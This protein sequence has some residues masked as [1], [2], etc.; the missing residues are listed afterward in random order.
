[1]KNSNFVIKNVNLV[2]VENE[3]VIKNIDLLI[4]DGKISEIS[5]N[6]KQ[7][8]YREFDYKDKYLCPGLINLHAHLF[9]SGKPSKTLTGGKKQ[10]FILKIVKTKLGDVIL[11]K[12]AKKS[13]LSELYS[14][15]TTVRSVGDF[16]YAD[17]KQR[18]LINSGK[19]LGPTLYC[20]GFAI[21]AP[22]GHGDK[23]FA[24]SGVTNEDYK[25][26]ID[27]NI[28]EGVDWIK[29]CTTGGVMDA[30]KVGDCGS[31]KMSYEAAKFC[32]EY[33]HEKGYRVA[34]HTEGSEGM[35]EG[36]ALGL[37]TIEHGAPIKD[38][39]FTRK[40]LKD[41]DGNWGHTVLITTISPAIPFAKLDPKI[42]LCDDV[43]KA[44][45]DIVANG[46]IEESKYALAHNITVG[47]GTDASCPYAFQYGMWR[48]L[49]YFK[50]Y[51]GVTNGFALKTATY[52][53]ATILKKE[54]EIGSLKEGKY[55]DAIVLL[56]N[57]LDDLTTLRNPYLVYK[58]DVRIIKKNKKLE[59]YEEIL[60]T[61]I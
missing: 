26:L 6:I 7:K 52:I 19:Y 14:G 47:L 42:T 1:M 39:D 29:I 16:Y 46:I 35:V 27:D 51:V 28:K 24:R 25:K 57:P 21:T 17:V 22:T 32:I 36:I 40:Y 15:T 8:A 41:N 34:S 49:C 31:Q 56:K 43:Q 5:K 12:L 50:K 13:L 30:K 18:N 23:T 45:A 3:K 38:D 53:N 37:D 11:A 58:R 61:L 9:G 54:N 59:K 48:E 2:D 4:E 20:S 33:A 10:D 55:F 60:D 44:N